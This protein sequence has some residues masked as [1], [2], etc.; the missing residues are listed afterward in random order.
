[1]VSRVRHLTLVWANKK[2]IAKEFVLI[3]I[4]PSLFCT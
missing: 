3:L 1:M 4:Y 2:K